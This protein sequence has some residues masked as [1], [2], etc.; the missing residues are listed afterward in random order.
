MANWGDVR[1]IALALPGSSEEVK[2]G[3]SAWVVG[4]KGFVWE[5]PLRKSDLAGAR[6]PRK[7]VRTT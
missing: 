5:R 2:R 4:K 6:T 3:T 7:R 1:K